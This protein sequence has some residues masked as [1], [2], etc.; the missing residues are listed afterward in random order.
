M[1]RESFI[2]LRLDYSPMI[3]PLVVW[4]TEFTSWRGCDE[5]GWDA[6][7][8]QFKEIIQIGGVRVGEDL[9]IEDTFLTHC[10]PKY[11]TDLSDYIIDLT[12]ISQDVVNESPGFEDAWRQFEDWRG[13]TDAYSFGDDIS[14]VIYNKELYNL[15]MKIETRDFYDSKILL[16][17]LGFPIDEYESSGRMHESIEHDYNIS[18]HNARDDSLSTA[19]VLIDR[20]PEELQDISF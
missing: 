12:G 20:W 14:V 11:N 7:E 2:S 17:S 4:D 18:V 1:T 16:E 15:D 9:E 3:S 19:L 6:S 13:N 10:K 5:N 8:K